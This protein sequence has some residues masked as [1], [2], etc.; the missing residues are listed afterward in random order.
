[1][2][3]FVFVLPSGGGT[4]CRHAPAAAA[5]ACLPVQAGAAACLPARG[6]GGQPGACPGDGG[7]GQRRLACSK[8]MHN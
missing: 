2:H 7:V 4:A 8:S 3:N 5:A 1:M 6:G